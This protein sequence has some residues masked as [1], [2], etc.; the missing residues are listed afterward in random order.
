VSSVY[1]RL[2][3]HT[4]LMVPVNMRR[5]PPSGVVALCLGAARERT[6][7]AAIPDPPIDMPTERMPNVV[8]GQG[9]ARHARGGRP[10]SIT[11]DQADEVLALRGLGWS[12]PR[13]ADSLGVRVGSVK[14][15][16]GAPV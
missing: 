9:C 15:V 8:A 3:N 13:I 14:T 16:L 11:A 7:L 4:R 1:G 10:R 5:D 12:M 2:I 6:R